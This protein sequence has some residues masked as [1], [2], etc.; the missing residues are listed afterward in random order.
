MDVKAVHINA[1]ISPLKA[2]DV[3]RRIQGL[4]AAEALNILNYTPRKA[5]VLLSKTL[6]S[7][8][9]NAEN[10]HKLSPDDLLVKE[11]RIDKGRM[12]RRI[13]PR[14]RGSASPIRRRMSHILV[15]VTDGVDKVA[16][17]AEEGGLGTGEGEAIAERA[18][19]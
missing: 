3:A 10:N 7:A 8:L 2:R 15:V 11:A 12:M 13:R 4:T 17:E 6:R 19:D 9:A 16:S 5:A 18:T 14:A 1:R